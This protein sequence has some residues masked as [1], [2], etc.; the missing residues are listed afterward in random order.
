MRR[1]C[2]IM[3]GKTVGDVRRHAGVVAG[4]RHP[5]FQD[6]NEPFRGSHARQVA[7]WLPVETSNTS[8]ALS[9][10]TDEGANRSCREMP[11]VRAQNPLPWAG[12]P[13]LL[14]SY[15]GHPSRVGAFARC[16]RETLARIPCEGWLATEARSEFLRAKGGGPEQ[17]QLEPGRKFVESHR[18]SPRGCLIR[19]RSAI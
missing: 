2:G 19:S 16:V 8:R 15:G 11:V 9:R 18:G 13:S 4:W 6:V 3:G 10:K 5:G 1:A 7:R 12:P 14:R 17:R